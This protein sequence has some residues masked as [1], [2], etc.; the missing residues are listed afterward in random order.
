MFLNIKDK[1]FKNTKEETKNEKSILANVFSKKY[2]LLYIVSLMVSI[3][4]MGQDLSPFSLAL[5]AAAAASEIPVIA[6]IITGLIGNAIGSGFST[7]PTY[8]VT[9]LLFF[10]SFLIK[11]PRYNDIEKNEKIKLGRR[12]VIASLLV[13]IIKVIMSGFMLYDLFVAI[14][15]TI[16][17]FIFY[18]IFVNS[19]IVLV[20]FNQRRAFSI[21][22]LMGTSLLVAISLCCFG[23]FKILGFSIKNVLSIFIVLL[24]GW[25][26]GILVGTTSGVTIGVTLGIIDNNEPLIVA[27]YAIS[28]MIAGA[29]NK[30]GRPGVIIGFIFGNIVL[31]YASNG[32]VENLIIFKEILIA[33]IALIAVPRRINFNIDNF[34]G[35]EKFLPAGSNRSLDKS[36]EIAQKLNNVSK[37]VEDIASTYKEVAATKV[38]E[39]DIE[40]K[41]KQTFIAELLNN[42][43]NMK[44]NILYDFVKDVE[45]SNVDNIFKILI[46]KQSITENDLIQILAK[47]NN[48]LISSEEENSKDKKDLTNMVNAINSAYKI[49]KLNFI[50]TN[51]L[52]EEKQNIEIQLNGVSKA[53]L[54][55]AE[56]MQKENESNEEYKDKEEQIIQLLKQREILVQ[57]I[58]IK[59]NLS[60][61]Y[62]IELYIETSKI[63]DLD[64][65]VE[66]ILTKVLNE[67]I[68]INSE[69]ELKFEKMTKYT[70]M[71]DDKFIITIGQSGAIKDNK[72]ISGDSILKIR[73]KDGKYLIAISDGMGSGPQARKSSQIV[74]K[75]LQRLLNSGFEKNTSID[76]INSSLL[77]VSEDVFATLDI[78]IADLYKGN[79]E[80]IKSGACPTYIKNN[81]KVQ[82]IKSLAL[83]AGILKDITGEV[84]DKDIENE[85][86]M[87][88]CTDGI[89]DSNI[90]YKNKELWVKYLLEDIENDN[91][92][93]IADI[94]LNESIDNNFGKIKDDMSVIVCKF[95]HK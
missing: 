10:A 82:I 57:D 32:G 66:N 68:I 4:N 77:N 51:R 36:K 29:L 86:I 17:I 22:E 58:S 21:E 94:I 59:K 73:L 5:V 33:G 78:A 28:G 65:I 20:D 54:N 52:K 16:I 76:L 44:E 47:E 70:C 35:K 80:F 7:I 3:I 61:R 64:K 62:I 85:D 6:I 1:I 2:I 30:L 81:K 87:I 74:V 12:L 19:L 31:S 27:A 13:N 43:E 41:N 60:N 42:L 91:P 63:K 45:G 75:M 84:F 79:I 90:E 67:K 92:Q 95:I 38:D 24:L 56:D 14:T 48:Y 55:I 53:I 83:P 26:N 23:D 46:E 25:K 15:V 34:V 49:G 89:I 8:I 18:K 93:K 40:E 88:M 71:A 39:E 37:A 50:W 69:E 72:D 9:L 11:E